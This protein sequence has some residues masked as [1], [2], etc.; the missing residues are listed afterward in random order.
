MIE[1]YTIMGDISLCFESIL[2]RL[3][4]INEGITIMLHN[5]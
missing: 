4:K 2:R 3:S 1:K 5:L